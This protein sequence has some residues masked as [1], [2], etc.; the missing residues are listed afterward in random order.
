MHPSAIV[1]MMDVF[2][3]A[4]ASCTEFVEDIFS[5]ALEKHLCKKRE[6][7]SKE[8]RRIIKFKNCFIEKKS[9]CAYCK[10][11]KFLTHLG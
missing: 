8:I 3:V 9:N 4:A 2:S 7:S 11:S 6:K 10:I 5:F 1:E